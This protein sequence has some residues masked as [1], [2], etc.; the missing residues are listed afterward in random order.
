MDDRVLMTLEYTRIREML[1]EHALSGLGRDL[2]LNLH[3]LQHPSAVA[4]AIAETTEARAILD[5][6][7]QIPLWGLGDMR[8]I[9]ER[10]SKGGILQAAELV[11]L[12]DCLRGAAEFRRYMQSKRRTAPNLSRYA[13]GIVPLRELADEIY[14][15]T[16][17]ARV[18][19]AASPRLAKV[20]KELRVV[21][22]RI[23]S[24]LQSYL[25]SGQYRDALQENLITMRGDRYAIPIKASHRHKLSGVVVDSS[26][27]GMTVYIEPASVRK[28]TDDLRILRAQEEAEEY[29]VLA[30]L[31]GLVAEQAASIGSNLEI[32]GVYDLAFAKGRLSIQFDA[33]PVDIRSDGFVQLLGARHPL[34]TG[35]V[36]PLDIVIGHRYRTLVITGPNTGGKTVALKT[37]GLLA[38]MAQSGL[39]IPV[40]GDSAISVFDKV[41][42]DIGDSQSIEQSLST[43]SGHLRQ[44]ASIIEAATKSS[45]VLLDE[46]G[47]G[48][49]PAEGAALA[50]AILEELHGFGCVTIAS[51]HYS[52][53]K[54]LA[55]VHPGFVN[56]RMDFDRETLRPLYHLVIGEAGQS[57]ALWIAGRL[58]L[59]QRILDRAR[60][61]L[62]QRPESAGDALA[63]GGGARSDT[64]AKS[65]EATVPR[66]QPGST[67][68]ATQAA[69]HQTGGSS[70]DP[71]DV[72][73][74]GEGIKRPWRL[75]DSVLIDT[76]NQQGVITVL[77]DKFGQMVVLSR[78]KRH[79]VH[80]RRVS[81]IIG[82]EHLYPEGYDLRTVLFTWQE[83]KTI[84]QLQRGGT[85]VLGAS[86]D[87]KWVK[88]PAI[89]VDRRK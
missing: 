23:K 42:A 34:I 2:A 44:I 56:G 48:T 46:I 89:D 6:G 32:M 12:A 13:E 21:E 65:P 18:A 71:A 14:A 88:T 86:S 11:R 78:G 54:R 33:A 81:L 15:S 43:F 19:D 76:I 53:V 39:H 29:Q 41:L 24:K 1:A 28:L 75:G 30:A 70:S 57:Q 79:T 5:G 7:G 36:V 26:G 20:R 82:A 4:A 85:E 63:D 67:A 73:A 27:S 49:D 58:G 16:D 60:E 55:D 35:E 84:H 69:G 45:L 47:T 74:D 50:M 59:G 25:T 52:D 64:P 61:H 72:A 9:V 77:P 10:A 83:R 8:P 22:D 80:E 40:S 37:V 87:A 68:V 66:A 3:P 38:L 62:E 17:G 31:S 51:T